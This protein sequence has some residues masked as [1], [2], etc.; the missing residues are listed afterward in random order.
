ME[1]FTAKIEKLLEDVNLVKVPETPDMSEEDKDNNECIQILLK[2][3]TELAESEKQKASAVH[4]ARIAEMKAEHEKLTKRLAEMK[5]DHEKRLAE[6]KAAQESLAQMKAEHEKQIAAFTLAQEQR[7]AE[8]RATQADLTASPMEDVMKQYVADMYER[9]KGMWQQIHQMK[10]PAAVKPVQEVKAPQAIQEVKAPQGAAEP[11]KQAEEAPTPKPAPAF[12]TPKL[13]ITKKVKV[14]S[15]ENGEPK[16]KRVASDEEKPKRVAGPFQLFISKINVANAA[17]S[18]LTENSSEADKQSWAAI[19]ETW[20][21]VLITFGDMENGL[22]QGA[23][24]TITKAKEM[25]EACEVLKEIREMRGTEQNLTTVLTVTQKLLTVVDKKVHGMK[26]APL[27]WAAV[28]K[29][30]PL[31]TDEEKDQFDVKTKKAPAAAKKAL[32]S[33]EAVSSDDE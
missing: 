2:E 8:F 31:L 7:I 24:E 15:D 1:E 19:R 12:K 26:L 14:N 29:Q 30:N 4:V 27:M 22:S 10:E 21:R 3:I 25:P 28:N 6:T 23:A 20:D 5:A 17:S 16:A 9:T 32:S 13:T 18:K 33:P 11:T